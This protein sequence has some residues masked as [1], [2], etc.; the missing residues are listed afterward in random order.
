MAFLNTTGNVL[1]RRP[2]GRVRD[3]LPRRRRLPRPPLGDR[4]RARL[5]V[6]H[7][8]A[9][10]PR[11][12]PDRRPDRHRQGGGPRCTSATKN[13][14]EYWTRTDAWYNFADNVRGVSHVLATVVEKP[15][16]R[17]CPA[18]R[19]AGSTA[20]WAPTTRSPGA[21]TTRAAGRSTPSGSTPAIGTETAFARPPRRGD[22][23]GG[24]CRRRVYS[25]CG[26]TVLANYEQ[27]KSARPPN[28][29]EP[30]GFD[31]A[32]RRPGHPDRPRRPRPAARPGDQHRRTSSRPIPVYTNSED[33][34]YGPAV[35]NDFATNHWV[36]LYYSPPTV[37]VKQS[38]GVTRTITTPTG[39]APTTAADPRPG[40]RGSAT[41]SSRG[42]S[43]ST[44]RRPRSTSP[45]SRR[46]SR[47]PNNRGACCHVAGDIDFDRTTT[48]GS[49]P[50]TTP[51]PVAATR[52]ASRRTTT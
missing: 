28:V 17:S 14:P 43:S 23:V 2:A 22:R 46:S 29:N 33:G 40:T 31:V 32:P 41:S 38:D 9:R 5:A 49:S 20:P 24:R 13:L 8:P 15:F 50:A 36:Y 45:R 25:D 1:D 6:P 42:S 7:R 44:G 16:T 10:H 11:H 39:S 26:A 47:S 52:A 18:P 3:L 37:T 34:L 27:T 4:D 30:I 48:S 35:D 19:S 12:Q 21:R 51:P